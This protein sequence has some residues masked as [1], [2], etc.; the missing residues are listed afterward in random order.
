MLRSRVNRQN[1]KILMACLLSGSIY[2]QDVTPGS[3]SPRSLT[4]AVQKNVTFPAVDLFG[5]PESPINKNSGP[6]I[7]KLKANFSGEV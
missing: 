2:A 6:I 7:G 3:A 1:L 4:D 5:F